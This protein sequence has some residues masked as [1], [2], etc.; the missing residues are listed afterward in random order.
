MRSTEQPRAVVF[1][2]ASWLSSA[3]LVGSDI[4]FQAA[5]AELG[6]GISTR[7]LQATSTTPDHV[8]L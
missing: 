6:L 3:G 1:A 2:N 7:L 5:V 4:G 8:E